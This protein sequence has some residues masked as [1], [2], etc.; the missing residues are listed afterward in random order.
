MDREHRAVL[1]KTLELIEATRGEISQLREEIEL[2]RITLDRSHNL[3]SRTES[4]S[5]RRV[6]VTEPL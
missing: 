4:S 2:T 6:S 3:L 5:L 1:I